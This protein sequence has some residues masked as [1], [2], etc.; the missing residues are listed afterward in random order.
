MRV[1]A[2]TLASLTMLIA[3]PVYADLPLDFTL[4]QLEND[5]GEASATRMYLL[6]IY[7]GFSWANAALSNRGQKK[8]FCQPE[9]L[10]ITA[11][12]V[13]SIYIRFAKKWKGDANL[14]A[15]II[16]ELALEEVFPCPE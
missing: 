5:K 15:G 4:E 6:G 2:G 10:A 8:I 7:D 3:S 14:P 9:K 12:Q 11:D 13:I 1:F 16:M